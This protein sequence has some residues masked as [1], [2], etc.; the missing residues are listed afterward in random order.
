VAKIKIVDL[1]E[2]MTIS[3]ADLSRIRGGTAYARL[4]QSLF[5]SNSPNMVIG[6]C[7]LPSLAPS[8]YF[9]LVAPARKLEGMKLKWIK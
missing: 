8:G 6:D 1:P 9:G 3:A 4:S 2:D 7:G 5:K